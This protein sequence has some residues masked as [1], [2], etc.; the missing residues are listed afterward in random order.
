M[1]ISGVDAFSE[2]Q[3]LVMVFMKKNFINNINIIM[4]HIMLKLLH[5][6]GNLLFPDL[7]LRSSPKEPKAKRTACKKD[8]TAVEGI[9]NMAY[10]AVVQMPRTEEIGAEQQLVQKEQKKS[11][12]P[13]DEIF[14]DW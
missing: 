3:A 4:A 2:D 6:T 9:F 10:V 8:P 14:K 12:G 7:N 1:P 5:C 11:R 13:A